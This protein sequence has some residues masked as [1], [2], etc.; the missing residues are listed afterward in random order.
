MGIDF[1]AELQDIPGIE[2][3]IGE[4]VS[5][6]VGTV[7]KRTFYE[8][9]ESIEGERATVNTYKSKLVDLGKHGLFLENK[10]E[11][12]NPK[13]TM[14]LHVDEGFVRIPA[15]RDKTYLPFLDAECVYN[16]KKQDIT[17]KGIMSIKH[18]NN[19]IYKRESIC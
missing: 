6:E 16:E 5:V 9:G 11:D 7:F 10:K 3:L 15:P 2:D 8:D 4:E 18:N 12:I 17:Y 19:L 1:H 13:N 14:I